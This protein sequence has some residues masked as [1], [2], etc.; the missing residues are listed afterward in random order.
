MYICIH[1]QKVF[2]FSPV[3]HH[4]LMY[5]YLILTVILKSKIKKKNRV[6]I[7][8]TKLFYSVLCI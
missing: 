2:L 4:F 1:K 8:N 7:L 5:I 6:I 3:W